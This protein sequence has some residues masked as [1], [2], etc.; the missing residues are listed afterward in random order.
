M[1]KSK[2]PSKPKIAK[3][4]TP[5]KVAREQRNGITRPGTDTV[6][7]MVW[8]ALDQLKAAGTDITFDAIRELVDDVRGKRDAAD[9][10]LKTQRQRW[11]TF[12]G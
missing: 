3:K 1:S 9:D 8:S 11:K 6:C 10:T 12:H 5:A 2:K 4:A 7:A